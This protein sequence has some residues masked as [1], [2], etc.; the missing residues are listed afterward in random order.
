MLAQAT[1]TLASQSKQ[2]TCLART[3]ISLKRLQES[4]DDSQSFQGVS[5]DYQNTD[6]FMDAVREAW[7]RQPVNLVLVWMHS[8]GAK[9]L[10]AL[11]DFISAQPQTPQVFH[12]LGSAA[13]NPA[14][15]TTQPNVENYHQI[16]LGFVLGPSGSR[17]L[18]H[19]EISAGTLSAIQEKKSRH[20]I[21]VME[22]WSARP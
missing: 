16:I 18:T 5:V 7:Q 8:S 4:L 19:E 22:P 15:G 21:G 12:V 1:S 3:E 9:S 13:A 11:F 6:A 2:I 10:S 17:W 14:E 20:I